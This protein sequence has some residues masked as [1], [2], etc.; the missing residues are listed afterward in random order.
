MAWRSSH[1]TDR[2]PRHGAILL[3]TF[4]LMMVMA[5][6]AVGAGTFAY[7]SLQTGKTQLMDKQALYVAEA[8]WQRA[9]QQLVAGTWMAAAS[10]GNT[11]TESFG[12]GEYRVTIVDEGGGTYTVTAE[13]YVPSQAVTVAKRQV[14]ESQFDATSTDG[15]NLSLAATA[16]ASSTNRS[17]TAS[18][19]KDG[20][21]STKWQASVNGSGWLSMDYGSATSLNKIVVEE[22]A[23][24]TAVSIEW[25]DD[26]VSWTSAG[27][28]VIESP[29]KTWTATFTAASHRYFRASVSASSSKKPAIEEMESYSATV[30]ALGAGDVTTQW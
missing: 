20:S 7:N 23:N 13:G 25:S 14:V 21:M 3:T 6:L 24:I 26:N 10:P 8:G 19:A 4:L 2:E 11:Y 15:T 16:A 17:N 9:R 22:D 1:P 18:K 12:A 30:S 29:S 5:G 28:S 27:A